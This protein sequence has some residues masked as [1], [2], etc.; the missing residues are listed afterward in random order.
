MKIPF[1][2]YSGSGN[3]FI[4][5][6][7]R[8]KV[9]SPNSPFIQRLCKRRTGIGAD[10]IILLET[11]HQADFKMCIFN[12]DGSEAEM[13]GNGVRCLLKFILALGIDKQS[14]I[15]ETKQSKIM[16]RHDQGLPCVSMP[17]PYDLRLNVT[18]DVE[19]EIISASFLNTGVPHVVIVVNDLEDAHWMNIAPKIRHHPEFD[20][21]GANVNF[22]KFDDQK[23]VLIRTYERGVENETLACGTG[24]T[25]AALIASA[26]YQ[27][28]SPIQ[29]IPRSQENLTISFV[30]SNSSFDQ[31]TLLGP[32][33]LIFQGELILD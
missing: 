27:L 33:S 2:K 25:A 17:A 24:A 19:G 20:P 5:I 31:V 14:Y 7:N 32:A 18:L 28:S 11:S 23:N 29:V 10:G 16:L 30:Y 1:S 3:D 13:C 8:K 4:L 26:L 22:I 12:A 21:H 15:I 6:D 9:F